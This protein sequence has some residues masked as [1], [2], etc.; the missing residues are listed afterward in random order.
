MKHQIP[1]DE[2]IKKIVDDILSWRYDCHIKVF[3]NLMAGY[4]QQSNHDKEIHHPKLSIFL[5]A[6]SFSFAT[7]IKLMTKS[8][9]FVNQK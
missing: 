7:Q 4:K 5:L 6:L 2:K 8:G 3:K 9:K 1:S